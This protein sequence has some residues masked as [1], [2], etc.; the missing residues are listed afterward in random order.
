MPQEVA[1]IK[2]VWDESTSG[3][4][5]ILTQLLVH[6]DLPS[7]GRL[8]YVLTKKKT[9]TK[10]RNSILTINP[11]SRAD[12]EEPEDQQHQVQ[13]PLP[14]APLHLGSQGHRQGREAQAEPSPQYDPP[15]GRN[16]DTNC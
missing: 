7:E 11:N 5:E 13:G 6:R 10:I 1:D 9:S 15:P 8:L 12:Q 4:I 16:D 2:K 3:K 14:E